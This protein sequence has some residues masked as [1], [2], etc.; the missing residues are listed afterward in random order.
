[1]IYI[2]IKHLLQ[3]LFALCFHHCLKMAIP[4][5]NL[6]KNIHFVLARWTSLSLGLQPERI[7]FFSS[8]NHAL[9]TCQQHHVY[10]F[11]FPWLPAIIFWMQTARFILFTCFMS[12]VCKIVCL[13]TMLTFLSVVFNS[14]LEV[15]F[16][17]YTGHNT[18]WHSWD[19]KVFLPSF[20]VANLGH[21]TLH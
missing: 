17:A 1:M 15:D 12:I 19:L 5:A 18:G 7:C 8:A 4:I 21:V 2:K 20:T 3:C 14:R 10:W 6:S 9:T 13:L 16:F 11:S